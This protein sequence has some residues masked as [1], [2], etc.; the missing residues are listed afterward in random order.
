MQNNSRHEVAATHGRLQ[1][2][3]A[4]RQRNIGKLIEQQA[5]WDRQS[6]AMHLVRAVI[7]L[8]KRLRVEHTDEKV[9]RSY[10][11]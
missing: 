5:D 11:L 3:V 1:A 2:F 6:S 10:M 8:L 7:K 9:E 4:V